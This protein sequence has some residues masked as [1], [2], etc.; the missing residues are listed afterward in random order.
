M[1][2]INR[3]ITVVD[4]ASGALTKIDGAAEG[5]A[6]SV[7]EADQRVTR[8][9]QSFG[10][11]EARADPVARAIQQVERSTLAMTRA[12]EQAAR[13]AAAEGVEQQRLTT[14]IEALG[15]ANEDRVRRAVS[16]LSQEE[17]ALVLN[18]TGY[19]RLAEGVKE[20]GDAARL[21]AREFQQ[22]SPQIADVAVSLLGGSSPFL[23]MVQQGPQA[24]DAVGGISRAFGL[25]RAAVMTPTAGILAATVALVGFT[26]IAEAQNRALAEL[27][28]R[29]RYTRDD[30]AALTSTVEAS[31][32]VAAATSGISTGDA[33]TAGRTIAGAQDFA[34][35]GDELTNL[36]KLSNDLARVMGTD[37]PTAASRLADAID[38]PAQAARRL[39]DEGL[40]TMDES[41]AR[42]I[43][44][45]ENQGQVAE[46]N[47]LVLDAYQ[48][49]VDQVAKTPLQEAL[50][51]SS[52]GFARLWQ[53]IRP[54]V[55]VIGN[56]LASAL[57][58]VIDQ[59]TKLVNLLNDMLEGVQRLIA[60]AR[61]LPA[62]APAPAASAQ[63]TATELALETVNRLNPRTRQ[64]QDARDQIT[65]LRA[66]LGSATGQDR[67]DIQDRIRAL[68]GQLA[69]LEGPA[70]GF[71]R[72]LR[73]QNDLGDI[74][75]NLGGSARTAQQA[76]LQ[77]R[78]AVRSDSG[79][80]PSV[81]M[82]NQAID[83][84]NRGMGNALTTRIGIINEETNA[85]LSQAE[86]SSQSARAAD[87]L[88][89][90]AQAE[91]QVRQQYGIPGTEEYEQRV[92][93]LTAAM[94]ANRDATQLVAQAQANANLQ[95]QQYYQALGIGA[96]A[97]GRADISA[98]QQVR[99]RFGLA[100]N[101]NLSP[102]Q[103]EALTNAQ[104]LARRGV[105]L[106]QMEDSLNELSK[107][108]EQAFDRIGSAITTAMAQGKFDMQ[109]LS[110]VGQAVASELTQ[111]FLKLALINP[112]R[113]A[114]FG[115]DGTNLLPTLSSVGG[116]VGRLLGNTGA[117]AGTAAI[118]SALPMDSYVGLYHSGGIVGAE[119][120]MYRA[121]NDNLYAVAP[122]YHAGLMPDE[123][124]AVLR[125][126]EG[127]FT[128]EQMLS[129]GPAG[130]SVS[131]GI[132]FSG[133]AG[134][135]QDREALA[136]LVAQQVSQQ[137]GAAAP[138]I[139]KA[140]HAYTM[141]E[142]SRGGRAAQTVG[143][144]A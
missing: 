22:L 14:H 105:D 111:A 64:R 127:V 66:G 12:Q 2:D 114:L 117:S 83:L 126:G 19:G 130:H 107:I 78:E 84:V 50:E 54:L 13:A 20:T 79:G 104:S 69:G 61:G 9:S 5:M 32:R 42:T 52:Q 57:A 30:Y 136:Q 44:R 37:V 6:R 75:A 137:L 95:Q 31:A 74:E 41:L 59:T 15:R 128:P 134:S 10:Q 39:A 18:R 101:D 21:T 133:D 140:S 139:V 3:I 68:G 34:G 91:A 118:S 85:L 53:N 49:S 26:A 17:R 55:D 35:T 58:W 63:R 132:N 124:P 65:R 89:I 46:A 123:L 110:N 33:R 141:G 24:A 131:V 25:L 113:N 45:L 138:G 60:E 48:R 93:S 1:T 51:R 144:R 16:G 86:A 76:V 135:P 72:G 38:H 122:R 98:E 112:L 92:R 27:S 88:R 70:A 143:R 120:T 7:N 103:Q 28:N 81:G 67:A 100:A 109:S 11:M 119:P 8:M 106:R 56:A 36:I 23:V 116:V 142:I 129:L 73:N 71:F 29:L 115:G 47:R 43:T 87:D 121:A 102:A 82:E 77:L 99:A 90:A 96:G 4:Q 40:R 125:K 97:Y 94:Q 80:R 108:G 62:A